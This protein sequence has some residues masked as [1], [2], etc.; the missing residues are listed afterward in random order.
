[1]D[2]LEQV[3]VD[4]RKTLNITPDGAVLGIQTGANAGQ[5]YVP[6]RKGYVW[7]CE[8]QAGSFSAPKAVILG[9]NVNL[10]MKPG[11]GVKLGY[12]SNGERCVL[13]ADGKAIIQQGGNPATLNPL[14]PVRQYVGQQG[15]ITGLCTPDNPDN[16][17]YCV[18][19]GSIF[20]RNR[21]VY[22]WG[23]ET[24]VD[25]TTYVPGTSNYHCLACVFI[26]ADGSGTEVKASTAQS[27]LSPLNLTDEQECI[28]A[29]T[30]GSTPIHFWRLYNGQT[31][32]KASDTHRDG[33]GIINVGI[34]EGDTLAA[35]LTT[36]N[37]T[38]TTIT[39]ISVSELEA[40]T[41]SGSFVASKSDYSA[42]LTGTFR[43]GFRR[44][45]GGNVTQI[46][47]ATISQDDDSA[48]TPALSLDVDTATQTARIRATGITAETWLWRVQYQM[49]KLP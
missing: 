26:L 40:Y 33:R 36:S 4:A 47:V 32:V 9:P 16:T 6:Y 34:G 25:L 42:S 35:I 15:I 1:M 38:I 5:I 8:Y 20:I 44:A 30:P 3:I 49:V 28:T 11:L 27:T 43:Y 22:R 23:N 29:A 13:H 39:S 21:I 45:S 7:V 2:E 31:A 18:V 37:N 14:D 19:T 48:G 17:L 12:D 10:E 24:K 46:A 41:I